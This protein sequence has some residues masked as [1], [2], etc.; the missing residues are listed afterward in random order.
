MAIRRRLFRNVYFI[1]NII[2][3]L[4]HILTEF[5]FR[6]AAADAVDMY[7]TNRSRLSSTSVGMQS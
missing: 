6:F 1:W 5:Q 2:C 7:Q 4:R 3:G